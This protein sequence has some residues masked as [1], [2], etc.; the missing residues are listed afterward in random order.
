MGSDAFFYEAAEKFGEKLGFHFNIRGEKGKLNIFLTRRVSFPLTETVKFIEFS[1]AC[2]ND[3]TVKNN[4][5]EERSKDLIRELRREFC[6]AGG[7]DHI[8]RGECRDDRL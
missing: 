1:A 5:K 6:S 7:P 2:D 4:A 8:L 3:I